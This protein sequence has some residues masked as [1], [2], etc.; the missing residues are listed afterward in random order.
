MAQPIFCTLLASKRCLV[1]FS[2]ALNETLFGTTTDRLCSF[3]LKSKKIT[4]TRKSVDLEMDRPIEKSGGR[5]PRVEGLAKKRGYG[6]R[7]YLLPMDIYR[8]WRFGFIPHYATSR[9]GRL[10]GH[11]GGSWETQAYSAIYALSRLWVTFARSFIATFRRGVS[12]ALGAGHMPT[13]RYTNA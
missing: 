4:A 13:P 1:H 5:I 8:G 10:G 7:Y 9:P 12:P 3:W 2:P 6:T 11:P